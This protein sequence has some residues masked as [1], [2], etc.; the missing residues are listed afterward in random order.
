MQYPDGQPVMLG[1]EV[2]MFPS[3]DPTH[4]P[5][6][7]I[8]GWVVCIFDEKAFAPGYES[9]NDLC[10]NG[11]MFRSV[12]GGLVRFERVKKTFRLLRRQQDA[13]ATS[14]PAPPAP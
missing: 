2:E 13:L 1:D 8:T 9:W 5:K 3:I 6:L 10:D 11:L 7:A 14:P 12:D 4:D